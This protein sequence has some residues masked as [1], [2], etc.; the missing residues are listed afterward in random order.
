MSGATPLC[1]PLF[2]APLA[3]PECPWTE[4]PPDSGGPARL[5]QAQ[6]ADPQRQQ[7]E[8]LAEA[9]L[10]RYRT[11]S[12]N[13]LGKAVST[14]NRAARAA[15][16][17]SWAMS[18]DPLRMENELANLLNKKVIQAISF[19]GDILTPIATARL[20]EAREQ[21][22]REA[23]K[24]AAR[25]K[26]HNQP[27]RRLVPA[28]RP[29]R[30]TPAVRIQ[31]AVRPPQGVPRRARQQSPLRIGES[32]STVAPAATPAVPTPP[33]LDDEELRRVVCNVLADLAPLI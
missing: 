9:L 20:F 12:L 4:A 28:A 11:M 16:E 13:R 14:K 30:R 18:R 31:R 7:D 6:A 5:T 24:A 22:K 32:A 10:E 3:V 27:T 1:P 15:R 29:P 8:K 33:K 19:I 26:A 17:K 23:A 2:G 25:K 21:A